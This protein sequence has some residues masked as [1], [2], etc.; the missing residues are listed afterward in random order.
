[1]A[2]GPLG[3]ALALDRAG[4]FRLT[5]L[6]WTREARPGL[7]RPQRLS[8][9][10]F[11]GCWSEVLGAGGWGQLRA[12]HAWLWRPNV[13]RTRLRPRPA[14]MDPSLSPTPRPRRLPR[15]PGSPWLGAA[16]PQSSH[17]HLRGCPPLTPPLCLSPSPNVPL[18]MRTPP[19]GVRASPMA[20]S[21]RD[22]VRKRARPHIHGRSGLQRGLLGD[23][24]QPTTV[25][26][27]PPEL[28]PTGPGT[29]GGVWGALH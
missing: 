21:P 9:V 4:R 24:T 1:M 20:A 26:R 11:S 17:G 23:T 16:S 29:G 14:G 7:R 12:P 19:H 3:L 8:A 18:A 6:R 22:D 5:A 27:R 15:A 2:I 13:L 25:T 10:A 28:T